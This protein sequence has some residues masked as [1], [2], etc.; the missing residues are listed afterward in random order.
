MYLGIGLAVAVGG[1]FV[2]KMVKGKKKDGEM[3]VTEDVAVEVL[4]KPSVEAPKPAVSTGNI[5]ADLGATIKNLT[6]NFR[7]YKV[8]T[9]STSLNIREKPDAKSKIIGSVKKDS[10]ISAKPSGVSGWFAYSTDGSATKGYVSST[11]LKLV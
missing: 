7:N 10:I 6:S 4:D 8:A 9:T 2:Y 5:F 3:M 1:F 11:Y